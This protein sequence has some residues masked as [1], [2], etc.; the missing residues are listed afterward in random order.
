MRIEPFNSIPELLM[1][2][3][4][5]CPFIFTLLYFTRALYLSLLF[6]LFDRNAFLGTMDLEVWRKAKSE[7]PFRRD[8]GLRM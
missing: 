6:W 2:V 1:L 3:M 8:N 7:G 4:H 5:V